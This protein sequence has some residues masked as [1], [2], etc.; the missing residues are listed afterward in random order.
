[1]LAA[2][3]P[4]LAARRRVFGIPGGCLSVDYEAVGAEGV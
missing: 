4:E 3:Y 2:A 1:M